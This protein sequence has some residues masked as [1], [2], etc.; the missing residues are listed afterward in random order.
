MLNGRAPVNNSG[1]KIEIHHIGQDDHGPWA[2]VSQKTHKAYPH[3]EYGKN[4][5]HPTRPVNRSKF[6]RMKKKYW[7]SRGEEFKKY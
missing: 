6:N 5:A 1:E 3:K 2:E 7:K 4:M